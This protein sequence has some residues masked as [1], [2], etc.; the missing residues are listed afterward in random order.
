MKTMSLLKEKVERGAKRK[1]VTMQTSC[2]DWRKEYEA[3]QNWLP[4]DP[5]Q[6]HPCFGE[7]SSPQL[8]YPGRGPEEERR[9]E[10]EGEHLLPQ[11]RQQRKPGKAQGQ[12]KPQKR[13][14][15]WQMIDEEVCYREDHYQAL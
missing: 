11:L 8:K 9:E 3:P 12:K 2:R 7:H 6:R 5:G 10:D 14:K 1:K 13:K 15:F 4:D